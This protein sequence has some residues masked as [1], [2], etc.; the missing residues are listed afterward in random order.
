[1]SKAITFLKTIVCCDHCEYEKEIDRNDVPKY[2]N[3]KCPECDHILIDDDDVKY[4]HLSTELVKS[5]NKIMGEVS[6]H[7]QEILIDTS[8]MKNV[9]N[10][11]KDN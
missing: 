3:K 1:M 4:F 9:K 8:M 5:I 7:S 6:G 11:A 2:H 10:A